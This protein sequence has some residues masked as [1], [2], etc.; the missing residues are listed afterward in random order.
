[1]GKLDQISVNGTSYEIVPE[2]APLFSASTAYAIG[3]CVIKDAVLYRFTAAH[4]AGAWIDTDAEEVTVASE[5]SVLKADLIDTRLTDYTFKDGY[6]VDTRDY[7]EKTNSG[8][9]YATINVIPY[10]NLH[11]RTHAYRTAGI[12][13]YDADGNGIGTIAPTS[14]ADSYLFDEL[15]TLPEGTATATI[16]C[17]KAQ[18]TDFSV[19]T[20]PLELYVGLAKAIDDISDHLDGKVDK[21]GKN[22]ITVKNADFMYESSNIANPDD[23][24][25]GE[26]VNQATGVFTENSLH[27]RTGFVPVVGGL[28]YCIVNSSENN[29]AEIRYAWYNANHVFISGGTGVLETFGSVVTAPTNAEYLVMSGNK[30]YFPYMIA[31]STAAIGYEE[32]GAAYLKPEYIPEDTGE[33]ILL[34][35]PSTIYATSG[36]ELNIYFE[37]IT[38]RWEEFEWNVQCSKGMQLERGYRVTPTDIDAGS[39]SLTITAKRPESSK[40]YSKSVT[41]VISASTAG[42][43]Q[44]KNIIIM[45]DSTTDNGGVIIKLNE[46]FES[47][48]MNVN[49]LGTR[50]TAPNNHEGR[51]GWTLNDYFTR[52]SITYPAG[53]PRGTVYNPFYNPTSQ[54]WDASYYF[55]NSGIS[56]PDYFI[57]N[58]GINDMFSFTSDSALETQ[59]ETCLGYLNS[60]VN[61]IK[62]VST[63]IKICICVTIPPNDSQDA[64]G[65]AYACGQTRD[66]Y[67]RNNCLWANAIID[68]FDTNEDVS[69]IPIHTNLD[70]VYNMGLETLPVN[71][72]NT[73]VTYDSPIANGGVHPALVG[74]WQIADVYTAFL[75]A[76]AS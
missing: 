1:M 11:I 7:Q 50:G 65:K 29:R 22:Q 35:L 43:G 26:F 70:T 21:D 2:I 5:L 16:T 8:Y 48:A 23:F 76:D 28:D 10:K 34:N 49:T 17:L 24:V 56:A 9:S 20:T 37:N 19:W 38:E 60:M 15:V 73:E 52:E 36:I 42:S 13:F 51:S 74:Y 59:I 54:T 45:G 4:P 53:D 6:Y 67:K 75:K 44:T 39:Y 64:F 72:R 61:S 33:D 18:K 27:E 25:V 57:I 14:T 31:Q 3:D 46:N 69:V 32:Y 30:S 68:E 63:N 58:M 71:S 12:C 66:R 62:A 55:A 40:L 41:L 47:D